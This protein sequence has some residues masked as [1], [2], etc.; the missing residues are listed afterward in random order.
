MLVINGRNVDKNVFLCLC[1]TFNPVNMSRLI[2]LSL[3]AL[4]F[5][6]LSQTYNLGMQ[7][8]ASGGGSGAQ[9]NYD[10]T[11]TVGEPVIFTLSNQDRVV[12]QGFHQPDIFTSV[13]TWDLDLRALGIEVFPNPT[14][15]FVTVRF[16]AGSSS[17]LAVQ[18]FDVFGRLIGPQE[19][20]DIPEGTILDC[21]NW[22]AGMYLLRIHDLK[23][24]A[25]A[26]VRVVRL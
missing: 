8:V 2:L 6:A 26:T 21:S 18:A 23:T 24:K 4:P 14:A 15:D 13:A 7:V 10:L 11:W 19:L 25:S 5:G 16:Q 3:L 17:A 12:T 1:F 9:A 20:L 22:P